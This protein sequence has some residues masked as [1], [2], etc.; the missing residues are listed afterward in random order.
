MSVTLTLQKPWFTT[1]GSQPLWE[2]SHRS[3]IY[4]PIHNSSK[5]TALKQQLNDFMVGHPCNVRN[6]IKVTAFR[7]VEN[8]CCRITGQL[9]RSFIVTAQPMKTISSKGGC[10]EQRQVS[11]WRD[12]KRIL[13]VPSVCGGLQSTP[14]QPCKHAASHT[15]A[16][17]SPSCTLFTS[18]YVLIWVLLIRFL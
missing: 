11:E 10:D 16:P 5:T 13:A 6:C 7:N 15:V 9:Q 3:G 8:H 4:M 14:H 12:G 18:I 1:C 17:R 2:G